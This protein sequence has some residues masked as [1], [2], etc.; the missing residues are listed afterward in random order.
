[1]VQGFLEAIL[2]GGEIPPKNWPLPPKKIKQKKPFFKDAHCTCIFHSLQKQNPPG[3]PVVWT[4]SQVFTLAHQEVLTSVHLAAM[5]KSVW[6]WQLI[7]DSLRGVFPQ[8]SEVHLKM[9]AHPW[10]ALD[11]ILLQSRQGRRVWPS[12]VRKV[13]GM[14][15]LTLSVMFPV[16]VF[17]ILLT[18]LGWQLWG[19]LSA[20]NIDHWPRFSAGEWATGWHIQPTF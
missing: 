2:G 9:A 11:S 8:R 15:T 4:Y 10:H 12:Q 6:A 1:M 20:V 19:L 5:W 18:L 17:S 14:M 7:S 13:M 16:K 3:N